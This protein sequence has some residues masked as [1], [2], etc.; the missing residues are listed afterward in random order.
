M[1]INTD[2]MPINTDKREEIILDYLREN[3]SISNKN[4][5]ELTGLK[6][7][8]VKKIFS[9]MVNKGLITPI[10]ERKSRKYVLAKK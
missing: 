10:G 6:D 5:C 3:G 9:K 4:A 2:K 7:S 8:T 1:P